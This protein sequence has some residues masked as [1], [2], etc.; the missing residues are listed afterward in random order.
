[1]EN[2]ELNQYRKNQHGRWQNPATPAKQ[3]FRPVA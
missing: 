1:M 3:V 2:S